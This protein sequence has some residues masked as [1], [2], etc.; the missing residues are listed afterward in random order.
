MV[1]R[2]DTIATIG[3]DGASALVDKTARARFGSLSV[4]D[5]LGQG[6]YRAAAAAAVRSA[7]RSD[8]ELVAQAYNSASKSNYHA[9]AIPRLFGVASVD[10]RRIVQL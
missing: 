8:L 4:Q 6:Q 10:I 7:Q 3:Y 2:E 9:D 5:L 1:K